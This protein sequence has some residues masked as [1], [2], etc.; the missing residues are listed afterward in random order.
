MTTLING[1]TPAQHAAWNRWHPRTQRIEALVAPITGP[2]D[3][4]AWFT[5]PGVPADNY[6]LDPGRGGGALMDVGFDQAKDGPVVQAHLE[7]GEGWRLRQED[8]P[9]FG[10]ISRPGDLKAASLQQTRGAGG[11]EF[12]VIHQQEGADFL[13]RH[14]LG[15]IGCTHERRSQALTRGPAWRFG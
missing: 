7:H 10:K 15:G 2:R 3:V 6:R 12:V 5:F 1:R 9:G 8:R 13:W 11:V 4:R 14:R